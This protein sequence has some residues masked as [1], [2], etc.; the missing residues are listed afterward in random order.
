MN[1]GRAIGRCRDAWSGVGRISFLFTAPLPNYLKRLVDE[2]LAAWRIHRGRPHRTAS[3]VIQHR[4]RSGCIFAC[5]Y[6]GLRRSQSKALAALSTREDCLVSSKTSSEK[7]PHITDAGESRK[8][9][10]GR[11]WPTDVTCYLSKPANMNNYVLTRTAGRKKKEPGG[12]AIVQGPAGTKERPH[13]SA[14]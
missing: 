3:K 11:R 14:I 8:H 10:G 2:A 12:G 6:A 7:N 5:P 9:A 13:P 1:G 4:P